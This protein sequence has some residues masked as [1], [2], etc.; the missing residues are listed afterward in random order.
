MSQGSGGGE[1]REAA[2]IRWLL[3]HWPLSRGKGL[4]LRAFQGRLE[5]S[6]ALIEIERGIVVPPELSDYQVRWGYMHGCESDPSFRLSR[7]LLAPGDVAIDIGANIG[8]WAMGAAVRVGPTGRV[9]AIE[10]VPATFDRLVRNARLNDLH[11][12]HARQYAISDRAAR[13]ELFLPSYDNSGHASLGK[14]ERVDQMIEVASITVDEF[15]TEH[16]IERVALVK[17]DTEGA[18]H[19][20]FA[21]SRRLLAG[22]EAPMVQFEVNDETAAVL[23][24]SSEAIKGALADHGYRICRYD[25]HHLASLDAAGCEPPGDLFAFK[26]HHSERHPLIAALFERSPA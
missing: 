10:P 11:N 15:C 3:R 6:G 19:R 23:N 17:T 22:N 12:I 13:I 26:P 25:G 1:L 20:V 16:G 18:E 7:A 14:R 21:G 4:I 2:T 9:Y 24:S 8:L 5:R